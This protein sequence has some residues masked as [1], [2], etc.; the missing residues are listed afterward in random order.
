MLEAALGGEVEGEEDEKEGYAVGGGFVAGEEEDEGVAEDLGGADWGWDLG[1][2]F[3]VVVR[4]K[5]FAG[6]DERD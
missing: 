4:G 1:G 5:R 3:V 6:R 2:I